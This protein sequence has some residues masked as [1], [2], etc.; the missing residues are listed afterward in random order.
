MSGNDDVTKYLPLTESTYYILF[1]LAEPLHGYGVMQ[2]VERL[3]EGTVKI[4]PGTLYGAF[5][6]LEKEKLIV[7]VGEKERR[8][9]FA[10]T[11][12]GRQ[13][14]KEQ[15]NRLRIMVHRGSEI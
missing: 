1:A 6:V 3:S 10:L 2:K 14:L 7:K 4:G 9:I 15:I 12:K 5:Q 11:E 8:K 13:V